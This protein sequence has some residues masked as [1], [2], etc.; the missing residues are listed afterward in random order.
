[1]SSAPKSTTSHIP[2]L[3]HSNFEQWWE[4]FHPYISGSRMGLYID[5]KKQ[6]KPTQKKEK[7][8]DDDLLERQNL[9]ASNH[10]L[11]P[12]TS[13]S[14]ESSTTKSGINI[15]LPDQ[16]SAAIFLNSL[17][18]SFDNTVSAFFNGKPEDFTSANVLECIQ[19]ESARFAV[20]DKGDSAAL[21]TEVKGGNGKGKW[22]TAGKKDER[23]D[24]QGEKDRP[25]C[26]YAKCG[27]LGH[28]EEQCH[29]KAY[30]E[31]EATRSTAAKVAHTVSAAITKSENVD[32]VVFLNAPIV[33][34]YCVD[35]ITPSTPACA[36]SK[37]PYNFLLD[38]GS[39]DN[40]KMN[41]EG[42]VNVRNIPPVRVVCANGSSIIANRAGDFIINTALGRLGLS[43]V[44]VVPG[45]THNLLSVSRITSSRKYNIDFGADGASIIRLED[46]RVVL[47]APLEGS[48]FVVHVCP[49]Q[50]KCDVIAAV[51]KPMLFRTLHDLFA[52]LN[53]KDL[54]LAIKSDLFKGIEVVD[55]GTDPFCESC[56]MGKHHVHPYKRSLTRSTE[57]LELISS[58]LAGPMPLSLG[59]KRYWISFID[60]A[61]RRPFVFFLAKKSDAAQ[62][63]K[64]S[65]ALVEKQTGRKIKAWRTDQGGEYMDHVVN[66]WMKDE[67]MIHETTNPDSSA[68]NGI[69]E[70]F[71]HTMDERIITLLDQAG[72]PKSFW[73][74]A[75]ALIVKILALSPHAAIGKGLPAKLW[76]RDTIPDIHR[77]QPFGCAGYPFITK[78]HRI[79]LDKKSAR[80]VFLGFDEGTKRYRVWD[81]VAR[82][83]RS[84]R[85][86]IFDR[87]Y[88]P[89]RKDP[90]KPTPPLSFD[91]LL[92]NYQ[93]EDETPG[94]ELKEEKV[95]EIGEDDNAGGDAPEPGGDEDDDVAPEGD[96]DGNDSGG[97]NGGEDDNGDDDEDGPPED[98]EP[99]GPAYRPRRNLQHINYSKLDNPAARRA[100][101]HVAHLPRPSRTLPI[102]NALKK[103]ELQRC[104]AYAAQVFSQVVEEVTS[105][106]DPTLRALLTEPKAIDAL[107][108]LLEDSPTLKQAKQSAEW[109]Y[110]EHAINE[111]LNAIETMKTWKLVRRPK[112]GSNVVPTHYVFK[113]KRGA[114]GLVAQF[115]ARLVVDGN[116][117]KD[118]D[119][120]EVFASVGKASTLRILQAVR[121]KLNLICHQFDVSTA[122]LGSNSDRDVYVKAPPGYV[123]RGL[124]IDEVLKGIGFTLSKCDDGLYILT[125]GSSFMFL[126]LHVDDGKIFTNDAKLLARVRKELEATFKLTWE[127]NPTFYLGIVKEHD[128]ERGI[129]T[130]RQ[131]RYLMDVLERFG[132]ENCKS[133]RTP[134]A[135]G[136]QLEAGTAEELEEGKNLPLGALVG[137]LL[138]A[139]C[140]TRPDILA[141]VVRI[142]S[143]VSKPTLKAFEAGKHILRYIKGTLDYGLTYRRDGDTSIQLEA[144]FSFIQAVPPPTDPLT[145]RVYSDSDFAGCLLTR[146]SMTG[147]VTMLAG[148]PVDW[149]SRRQ[150]TVATST[151]HA[152]YHALSETGGS[153]FHA[154]QLMAELGFPQDGPTNLDGDNQ[155]SLAVAN[156]TGSHKRSKPIDI[157]YHYICEL[158][159]RGEIKV[160]YINTKDNIADIMTKGLG[161]GDHEKFV[162]ALGL[163]AVARGGVLEDET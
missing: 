38:S 14:K 135:E 144:A 37:S 80:C 23:R 57:L 88:F 152:K 142:A 123:L 118:D 17:P 13:T 51:T 56:V 29:R 4:V 72:L 116:R 134:I 96:G 83:V 157:H 43:R 30:D 133:A 63:C 66:R 117:Q 25:K 81:P 55:D 120:G 3:T 113:K 137:S 33:P 36:I 103:A 49:L 156:S 158:I 125:E 153:T 46:K 53:Y 58:D 60:N 34:G 21:K 1:M 136:N 130:L 108:A 22:S 10:L 162:R 40:L 79:K 115:E 146:Q 76:P 75:G 104:S 39:A 140:W 114:D 163:Q 145:L 159:E 150:P 42:L 107:A 105:N 64:D 19:S 31:R 99:S 61:S 147:N 44:I 122:F 52:H 15:A 160:S 73:A 98:E 6:T 90:P 18:D 112:D 89:L 7:E 71:N 127:E 91:S 149:L 77:L 119:Y 70:R 138:Y 94:D 126:F 35:T 68:Q 97:E 110:W 50:A 28:T 20:E 87:T 9:W 11:F 143:F 54:R 12:P 74:E 2:T 5:G 65:K 8:D 26:G 148:G 24:N 161:R 111:E 32:N 78:N 106:N 47:K 155:G 102:Q 151:C 16:V 95:T 141:A 82:R 69:A 124:R 59:G 86:V 27:R 131:T 121:V 45:L 85:S 132:M 129:L 139:A 101:A 84:S 67:G 100:A 48:L 93:A 128:R 92:E 41:E 109:K 154:R 62:A